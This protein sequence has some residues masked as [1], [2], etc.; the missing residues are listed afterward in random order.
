MKLIAFLL[1]LSPLTWEIWNDK[2]GETAK[3]KKLD[4]FIRVLMA[5]IVAIVGFFIANK[6]IVDGFN[7]SLAIHFFFFDYAITYILQKRGVIESKQHWFEYLG[8]AY[9]ADV[10][11]Q[12]DPW[13]R[14]IIKAGIL[15]GALII[16][17]V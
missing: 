3:E 12:F 8:K 5:L 16:Y 17:F 14:F 9:T 6:P 4:V 2:D 10:L 15:V 11:R 13:T 1:L 7:L